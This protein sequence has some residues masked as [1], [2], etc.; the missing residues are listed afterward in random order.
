[1]KL[2]YDRATGSDIDHLYQLCKQLIDDYENIER[3]DY[4]KVLNW[5]RKR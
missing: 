4:V 5:V 1:M 2:T 3:I